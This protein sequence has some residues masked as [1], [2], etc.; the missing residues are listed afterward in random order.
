[1]D[2]L[3]L[4]KEGRS[5]EDISEDFFDALQDAQV[6]YEE[7]KKEQEERAKAKA[8]A[9]R[10]ME[11][12]FLKQKRADARAAVGAAI[13]NYFETLGMVMTEKDLKDIDLIVEALPN[14]KV[15]KT[16]ARGWF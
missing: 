3:A 15:V 16:C 8:E 6:E 2:I 5:V 13:V 11:E 9:A 7:W 1:M 10:K 4:L 14:L 12:E